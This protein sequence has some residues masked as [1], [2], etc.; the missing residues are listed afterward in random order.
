MSASIHA[1]RMRLFR[2]AGLYLVTSQELSAGR[3]TPEIIRAALAAGVRL[4]Q[5]R[6]K[7][8]LIDE[9]HRLAETARALTARAGALLIVNDRL[10]VAMSVGA[11]GVHLGQTD[12]PVAAARRLAPDMMIGASTHSVAEARS[13]QA[14]GASYINIGPIFPTR[15]KEHPGRYLG[16]AGLRKISQKTKIP[17]TVMGGIKRE[18]IAGLRRCGARIIAVVTA[19]TAA[20]DPEQ[21][22][23]DLLALIRD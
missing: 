6:E 22:A 13:A 3:A 1:K 12:F 21:A 7:N 2:N 16:L 19:I 9:Y 15:T 18:H 14:A 8:M 20:A 10:D 5:L 4:I 11:D 23:R 17:W